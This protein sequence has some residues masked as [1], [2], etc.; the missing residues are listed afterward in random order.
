[1]QYDD[2]SP[3]AGPIPDHE[4]YFII[5]YGSLD[6]FLLTVMAYDR[7]VAICH[8]LHYTTIMRDKSFCSDTSLNELL[9]HMEGGLVFLVSLISLMLTSQRAFNSSSI[10]LIVL[11]DWGS[12]CHH[13]GHNM[14][15]PSEIIDASHKTCK[16]L[17]KHV[18]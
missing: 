8:P 9:I 13:R 18:I 3:T 16:I 2:V 17:G 11:T 14:T 10:A 4:V 5:F 6:D 7:Y 12:W 1:M 15:Q